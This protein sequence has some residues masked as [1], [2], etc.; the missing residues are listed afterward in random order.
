MVLFV[1]VPQLAGGYY[2]PMNHCLRLA[3]EMSDE[4]IQEKSLAAASASL[5]GKA[6]VEKAAI[7]HQHIGRREMTDM[8]IETINPNAGTPFMPETYRKC[9]EQIM[10]QPYLRR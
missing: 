6:P 5:E 7:I 2:N 1:V 9:T 4:E 3:T 10:Q 8:I